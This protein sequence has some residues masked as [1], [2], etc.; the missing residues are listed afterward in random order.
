MPYVLKCLACLCAHVSMCFTCFRAYVVTCFACLCAHVITCSCLAC[1]RVNV[2]RVL[3][4]PTCSRAITTNDKYKFSITCFL[5]F[6]WLF[7]VFFLWNETVVYSCISLTSQKPLT[8]AMTN[9]VQWNGFFCLSI[10]LSYF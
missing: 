7:F 8:G 5:T 1:S 10:T 4:V 3:C 6:L 2:T 9:F